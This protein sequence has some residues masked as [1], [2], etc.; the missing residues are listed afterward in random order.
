M[1]K[2]SRLQLIAQKA[3]AKQAQV[4]VKIESKKTKP[5]KPKTK[6]VG[7]LTA[8]QAD[9]AQQFTQEIADINSYLIREQMK[10]DVHVLVVNQAQFTSLI[11]DHLT[12]V[13][14]VAVRAKDP[15]IKAELESIG[16]TGGRTLYSIA[17]KLKFEFEKVLDRELKRAT[18]L[19]FKKTVQGNV[20]IYYIQ[21][22]T[23]PR[24]GSKET[25]FKVLQRV[26]TEVRKELVI[27]SKSGSL[28]QATGVIIGGLNIDYDNIN[29]N[30][31]QLGTLAKSKI[32]DR[33][34][35]EIDPSKGVR[36]GT[37]VQLGHFRGPNAEAARR[38]FDLVR[39]TQSGIVGITGI[40]FETHER[41]ETIHA[42]DTEVRFNDVVYQMAKQ[43]LGGTVG[44]S[45]IGLEQSAKN[46]ISGN[47]AGN[48]LR[49]LRKWLR[50]NAQVIVTMKGSKP[51][52]NMLLDDIVQEFI[53]NNPPK[54]TLNRK[55]KVRSKISAK[56]KA[57]SPAFKTTTNTSKLNKLLLGADDTS[58]SASAVQVLIANLNRKLHDKIRENMGKGKSKK[59]LNYRTGRFAKSA[60]IKSFFNVSEKNALGAVV[61]YRKQPYGVFEPGASELATPGRS[62]KRIFARSIRQLLQEERIARLRR[63]K[64]ELRG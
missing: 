33:A 42:F 39:K 49:K 52:V 2:R 16:R 27:R 57:A 64:V 38:L 53:G 34:P 18:V 63:V 17:G 30:A 5:V 13:K 12:A 58:L 56:T 15:Q 32:A 22:K 59:I 14:Q 20:S 62:P 61:K 6:S 43:E 1:A 29:P 35:P 46:S 21:R 4:N 37:G 19:R 24:E 8:S 48:D 10:N 60:E 28:K 9:S 7:D 36:A 50:N 55:T 26:M 44:I 11:R 23:L 47:K 3:K 31:P 54:R 40:L 51:L 25:N 45:I 41:K